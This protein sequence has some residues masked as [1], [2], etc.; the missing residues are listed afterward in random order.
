MTQ[1]I[2]KFSETFAKHTNNIHLNSILAS[3]LETGVLNQY[4]N[5]NLDNISKT[6]LL[7]KLGTINFIQENNEEIL[8]KIFMNIND[9]FITE[10]NFLMALLNVEDNDVKNTLKIIDYFLNLDNLK[11]FLE[12]KLKTEKNVWENNDIVSL[13]SQKIKG[14]KI[15][16][17]NK[18]SMKMRL[19]LLKKHMNNVIIHSNPKMGKTS[20]VESLADDFDIYKIEIKKIFLNEKNPNLKLFEILN[21][22][23]GILYFDEL[24]TLTPKIRDSIILPLDK[25]IIVECY[26]DQ[27]KELMKD[28]LV[29]SKHFN[30]LEV[31]ETQD[32][33]TFKIV[34]NIVSTLGI[35]I[36]DEI[37]N[38]I[39]EN[40]TKFI[41]NEKQPA[42]AINF[43]DDILSLIKLKK[44][45][46]I[47]LKLNEYQNEILKIKSILEIMEIKN[48]LP[49]DIN[50][51]SNK[52]GKAID[53]LND[54]NEEVKT[55]LLNIENFNEIKNN[56]N[57]LKDKYEFSK[58]NNDVTIAEI[59]KIKNEI[60]L[61]NNIFK[62]AYQEIEH[63][64]VVTEDIVYNLIEE[65]SGIPINTQKNNLDK[66][67]NMED[68]LNS[69]IKGQE[70]AVAIVSATIKRAQVGLNDSNR[71]LGV[72]MFLGTTGVGKTYLAKELSK[73]IF[74]KETL[75]RFDMSEYMHDFNVSKLFGAPPGYVGYQN[76]GQLTEAV[77]KNPYSIILLDE[78]E[79]AHVRIFDA[80]L[81][82]MD[83]GRMT[84]GKGETIDFTNTII[85][86]TTNHAS[87]II[88]SCANSNESY[89]EIKSKVYDNLKGK[90]RPEF[91]NRFDDKI[92]FNTLD[93]EKLLSIIDIMI[94]DFQ[95][96]IR[97]KYKIFLKID[98]EVNNFI[99][100]NIDEIHY[101]ARPIKRYIEKNL[102]RLITN[103]IFNKGNIDSIKGQEILLTIENN[104]LIL[105][106]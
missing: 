73:F 3:I 72:F 105:K 100:D 61:L 17:R 25:K 95:K 104:R 1:F 60:V 45:K 32:F 39:I 42:K 102:V 13:Y 36:S 59:K 18:E 22:I 81:Q 43:I 8:S 94:K 52:L 84:D 4:A 31:E 82:V 9:P 103:F 10:V 62:E 15:L 53:K 54:R 7:N 76:G 29:I 21:N 69:R 66:F 38:I 91:L 71:P 74:E 48:E 27:L 47:D 75:I 63:L 70:R 90:F 35:N 88:T 77:K 56:L 41:H 23:N 98:E 85:I 12:E 49:D 51:F 89:K 65:K 64:N 80:F 99:L 87:E 67:K 106:D 6:I 2:G 33:E 40:S 37:I 30:L 14:R 83:D 86:M 50:E 97:Q 92:I 57:N 20:I 46:N 79:K 19:F 28:D 44:E 16:F 55:E 58:I 68:E 96:N 11:L 24:D 34:Q 93:D 26:T 5:D 101:G 78:I